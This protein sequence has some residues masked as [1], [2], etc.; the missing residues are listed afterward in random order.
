MANPCEFGFLIR[1]F[2]EI[3]HIV[4]S[5]VYIHLESGM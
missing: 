1:F 3:I 5:T 4:N 2:Q